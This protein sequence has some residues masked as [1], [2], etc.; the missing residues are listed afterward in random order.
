MEFFKEDFVVN[1]IKCSAKIQKESCTKFFVFCFLD[2][3]II[4][5]SNSCGSGVIWVETI[6]ARD[7]SWRNVLL[8][9]V[10]ICKRAFNFQL[11]RTNSGKMV[12][13]FSD[14]SAPLKMSPILSAPFGFEIF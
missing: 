4:E 1:N 10:G 6:V 13:Q 2:P 3:E 8:L 11:R 5:L 14:L 7:C 9:D 12:Y